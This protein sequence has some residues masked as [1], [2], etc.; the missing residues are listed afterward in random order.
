MQGAAERAGQ[1]DDEHEQ[2]EEPAPVDPHP[3]SP[4]LHQLDG[5]CA[6]EHAAMVAQDPN[7][8]DTRRTEMRPQSTGASPRRVQLR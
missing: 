3:D 2:H 4:H 7:P 1:Q 6:S 8:L 5:A